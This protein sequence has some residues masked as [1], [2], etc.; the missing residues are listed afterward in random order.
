MSI[1]K[2]NIPNNK[3]ILKDQN[4]QSDQE[5]NLDNKMFK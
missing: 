5:G 3:T 2:V 4:D 1:L